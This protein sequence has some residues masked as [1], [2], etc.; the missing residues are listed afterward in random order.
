MLGCM[1]STNLS[2]LG[3]F[4]PI[5]AVIIILCNLLFGIIWFKKSRRKKSDKTSPD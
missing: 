5:T 3:L 1:F 4:L 2:T